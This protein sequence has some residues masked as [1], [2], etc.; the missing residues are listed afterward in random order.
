MD[1]PGLFAIGF[2]VLFVRFLWR[3]FR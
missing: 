2:I 1:L 3:R